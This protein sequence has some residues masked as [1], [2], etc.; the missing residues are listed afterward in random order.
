MDTHTEP[1][2]SVVIVGAGHA[3]A[4][5]AATL[6]QMKFT[7]SI[8]VIGDETHVPY[9]RP[10]LSKKF[11]DDSMEQELR[12]REFYSDNSIELILGA[13]VASIDSRK[14]LVHFDD[15]RFREYG[16]V[17]IAT[18]ATPR[19]IPVPEGDAMGA[20]TLRTLDDARGLGT[21]L[22]KAN[23]L[24]VIGGGYVGMEVAAVARAKGV[25]VT[26][27]E[28]ENRILARVASEEFSRRLTAHHTSQ[29]TRILTSCDVAAFKTA[30][31]TVMAVVL[32]DGTVVD[33]DLVLVGIG[34]TPNI[35]LARGCGAECDGGILVDR[36]GRTTVPG[37]MAIGDV[38]VRPHDRIDGLRR[39]ESIPSA[40]EQAKHAASAIVGQD[41][42]IHEIPWFWSDQFDLKLKMAGILEEGAHTV[43]RPGTST[44]SYG[45]FHLRPDGTVCAVETA[46][47]PQ[48]FMAGK[49]MISDRVIIDPILL[50]DNEI[51]LR[52][53]AVAV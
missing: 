5:L 38:T 16:T 8:T 18:G 7:G 31:N 3:G 27:V 15:G 17:V 1:A 28:R 32:G 43:V 35:D 42:G 53:V 44:D 47:N 4:T 11:S 36:V 20:F 33:C 49:K 21:A 26:I 46:N 52:A 45:L 41:A 29:G 2:D 23:A 50:G 40:V 37:V 39:L 34:A 9:H 25:A 22:E 48:A 6:R 13:T 24:V 51:S 30:R 19:T 12:P 10:P 14:K